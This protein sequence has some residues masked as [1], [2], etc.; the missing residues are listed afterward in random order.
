[1]LSTVVLSNENQTCRG[2][3]AHTSTGGGGC[4]IDSPTNQ[5]FF[6]LEDERLKELEQ[7]VAVSFWEKADDNHTIIRLATSGATKEEEIKALIEI[8]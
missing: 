2:W 4:H 5:I 6:V 3:E 8:L 7:K 1:M